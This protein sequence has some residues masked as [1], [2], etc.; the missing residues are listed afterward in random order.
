[1]PAVRLTD[2]VIRRLE[3]PAKGKTI[4]YDRDVKRFGAR[5]T[6]A[7][8]KSFILDYTTRA[9]TQ[10]QCT[11]GRCDHWTTTDARAEAR[12]LKAL[13]DQGG[14]P[15]A[16]IEAE[17]EAPT[18]AGLIA[19]F[20]EEHLPRKR[21]ATAA[22]YRLMI[23]KYIAPHFGNRKVQE[24]GFSDCDALHRKISKAGHLY[25][26]NRV[27]ALLS[28]MFTLSIKWGWRESNPCRGIEKNRE[29]HRRRY[30]TPDEMQHLTAALTKFPEQDVADAV[31]LLLLTGARKDEVLSMKWGDLKLTEG[32]WT[33]PAAAVKQNEAHIVPLS[34]PARVLLAERMGKKADNAIYVFPGRGGRDHLGDF[35]H[36]WRRLLKAAGIKNLRI[37]D[38][39]HHFASELVSG[40]ASLPLIGS[41]L[42]HRNPA[43]TARYSHLYSDAQLAAVERVGAVVINA[44]KSPVE[45]TP[46]RRRS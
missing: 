37:H 6:A 8:V 24:I 34:A 32:Q 26:A 12:R 13:I 33:K 31:R 42:G 27:A 35:W 22:D 15:L 1:M 9:G 45:P 3:P 36:S 4:T 2:A 23:S 39:R 17:R 21:E 29:H 43:T 46:L 11:I 25:R 7:G 20:E 5:T 14:D 18:M 44:G 38:L 10:R 40:G 16:E 41:L 28:K 19:R 30:L